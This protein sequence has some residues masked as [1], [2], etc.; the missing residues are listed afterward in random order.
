[1][2]H[3]SLV[4]DVSYDFN[5]FLF[6]FLGFCSSR[7]WELGN[8]R[9]RSCWV[10]SSNLC[11]SGQLEARGVWGISSGWCSRRTINDNNWSRKLPWISWWDNWPWLNGQVQEYLG[12]FSFHVSLVI[13]EKSLN[14]NLMF[15]RMRRQAERWGGELFQEDVEFIDVKNT[16]FTVRSTER[17]V[18]LPFG[19][20][21]CLS[22]IFLSPLKHLLVLLVA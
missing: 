5:Y 15:T 1:M 13:S 14:P 7:Y 22:L 11:C 8:S 10:Y 20:R 21:C 6:F 4:S 2:L 3:S 17:K 12:L 18:M 9:I 16:P 19:C